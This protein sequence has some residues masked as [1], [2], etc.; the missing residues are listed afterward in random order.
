[1][2]QLYIKTPDESNEQYQWRISSLANAKC[3]T[4][5]QAANIINATI[6]PDQWPLSSSDYRKQYNATRPPSPVGTSALNVENNPLFFTQAAKQRIE[7]WKQTVR[8]RNERAATRKIIRDAS[9]IDT[10]L[11]EIR[12]KVSGSNI[13]IQFLNSNKQAQPNEQVMI[14][15]LSDVH[16]GV[17]F[18]N[19]VGKYNPQIAKSYIYQYADKLIQIGRKNNIKSLR[20]LLLGDLIH[21]AIHVTGRIQS[22]IN[23]AGQITNMAQIIG[24]FLLKLRRWF[25]SITVN[26]V[27]GN[28]SRVTENNKQSILD[29]RLDNLIFYMAKGYTFKADPPINF[30]E[31]KDSTMCQFSIGDTKLVAVHGDLDADTMSGIAKLSSTIGYMPDY[32]LAGHI[33]YV[34]LQLQTTAIIHNG[35][36]IAGG[37]D[38]SRKNRL[39]SY[40]C[41]LA[42][43]FTDAGKLKSLYPITFE[44]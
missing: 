31:S 14:A 21:G 44:V 30:Q 36:L 32:I 39:Q 15:M 29:E 26:T 38:Y 33:H 5:S 23:V 13:N 9:N 18:D 6:R 25:D 22:T 34:K 10:L 8:L 28:H 40:P 3:I 24:E 37:D 4:W 42:L 12:D 35:S 20:V 7:I 11:Q 2:D 16:Y 27:N 1:M 43:V 17:Q 19:T 41:Q